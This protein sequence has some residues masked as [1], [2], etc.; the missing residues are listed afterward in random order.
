M[1]Q[2]I[3]VPLDGSACAEQAL[4]IA[5]RLAGTAGGSVILLR[6]VNLTTEFLSYPTADAEVVRAAI[7][8]DLDEA[9]DYLE[10]L[11]NGHLT[12]NISSR[13]CCTC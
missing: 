8:A 9:S 7:D 6:V 4:P 10:R 1:F 11:A 12:R 5:A 3:L 13:R 2:R